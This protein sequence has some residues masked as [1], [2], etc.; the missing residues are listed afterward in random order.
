M[1]SD[2]SSPPPDTRY[3]DFVLPFMIDSSSLRGRMVRLGPAM[4]EILSRHDYPASV[5]RV[6]GELLVL[7]SLLGSTLKFQGI[8]TIQA[9]GNGPVRFMVADATHDGELRGYAEI[10]DDFPVNDAE[11]TLHDLL[12][13]GHLAITIDPGGDIERYQGIVSLEG[14]SLAEC[15]N[16]YFKQSEQIDVA[17]QVEVGRS[18]EGS[19]KGNWEGAAIML[20]KLPG[21]GPEE[22]GNNVVFLDFGTDSTARYSGEKWNRAVTFLRTVTKY[23]LLD[24]FLS[25]KDLLY[26][27]FHE[28]GVRVF[29]EYKLLDKCRCS[30]DRIEGILQGLS[31]EELDDMSDEGVISVTCQFCNREECFT[32]K[33]L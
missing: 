5:S 28:D 9:T 10:G 1:P 21:E 12:G 32:V 14:N 31:A 4:Q 7:T 16:L 23:E 25:P 15:V 17:L 6:L 3:E 30:R 24:P 26:R 18:R 19:Q 2:V 11:L 22:D 8:F 27:L 33:E 20:Q 29:D 13:E